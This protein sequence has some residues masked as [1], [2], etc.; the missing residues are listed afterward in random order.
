MLN[1]HHDHDPPARLDSI[2][3]DQDDTAMVITSRKVVMSK[4]GRPLL[5]YNN[6]TYSKYPYPLKTGLRWY[7]SKVKNCRAYLFTTHDNV[8]L[9]A[10]G[11]HAH[12]PTESFEP[13]LGIPIKGSYYSSCL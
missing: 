6:Y 11:S 8:V 7:C 12:S 9:R 4:R 13:S 10:Y 5:L 3:A 2:D 1:E